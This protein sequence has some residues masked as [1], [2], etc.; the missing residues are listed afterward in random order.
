M[1][2]PL[3]HRHSL[4]VHDVGESELAGR[5]SDK[6]FHISSTVRDHRDRS[7]SCPCFLC[8]EIAVKI[9]VTHAGFSD[10]ESKDQH[11]QA[12][13]QVLEQLDQKMNQS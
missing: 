3:V 12:W 2:Q 10:Q 6:D 8:C 5:P 13:P 1:S 9:M 11:E 7:L 4:L